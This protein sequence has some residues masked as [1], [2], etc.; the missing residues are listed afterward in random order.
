MEKEMADAKKREQEIEEA[1]VI[2]ANKHFVV[3]TRVPESNQT[4]KYKGMLQDPP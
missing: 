1:K 2:V 4:I 3:N